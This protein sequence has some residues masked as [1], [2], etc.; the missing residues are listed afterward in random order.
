MQYWKYQVKILQDHPSGRRQIKTYEGTLIAPDLPEGAVF[1]KQE[2]YV[3][4]YNYWQER[5]IGYLVD[6][7]LQLIESVKPKVLTEQY[8]NTIFDSDDLEE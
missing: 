1:D 6:W 2:A 8:I 7:Q 3:V 5:D 4:L